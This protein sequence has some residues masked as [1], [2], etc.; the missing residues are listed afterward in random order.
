M[1]FS[2]ELK[3]LCVLH[4]ISIGVMESCT[5]GNIAV[6]ITSVPGS[7]SYFKGGIVAYQNEVKINVLGLSEKIVSDYSE[8]SS[9]SV[10][11]MATN[12]L[13]IFNVDFS[14]ATSGY[15]GPDGGTDLNPVGTVF[16]AVAHQY[17]V[18]VNRLSFLGD[19]KSITDQA[20][21]SA[22]ELLLSEIKKI[23]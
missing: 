14:I 17:A 12:V 9:Q 6:E 15:T 16:I 7:S 13:N 1:S 19:R 10:K 4:N 11:E 5:G 21:Q 18:T 8:V 20:V 2:N 3:R 22:F 23:R